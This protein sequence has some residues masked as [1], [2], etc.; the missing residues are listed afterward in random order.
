MRVKKNKK[1]YVSVLATI[2]LIQQIPTYV[3]A[4]SEQKDVSEV[5]HH[6]DTPL[7]DSKEFNSVEIQMEEA[8]ERQDEEESFVRNDFSHVQGIRSAQQVVLIPDV[9]L[10]SEIE[11]ALGVAPGTEI[12]T[13]MMTLLQQIDA[14]NA[15]IRSLEGLQYATRLTTLRV[16]GNHIFDL[17]PLS[18]L[19]NLWNVS[20]QNQVHRDDE[21]LYFFDVPNGQALSVN[22]ANPIRIRF[23][24]H[25]SEGLWLRNSSTPFPLATAENV[26]VSGGIY[27]GLTTLSSSFS[28]ELTTSN[29]TSAFIFSGTIEQPLN[30]G[31]PTIERVGT[32]E[33]SFVYKALGSAFDPMSHVKATMNG[34]DMTRFIR[35]KDNNVD[36]NRAGWYGLN[37]GLTDYLSNNSLQVGL[38]V[39]VPKTPTISFESTTVSLVQGAVFDPFTGVTATAFDSL[40]GV[41]AN[42]GHDITANIEVVDNPVDT[43]I[44]GTYEVTYK[45]VDGTGAV[46]N[47]KR[48]VVVE[49]TVGPVITGVDVTTVELGSVFD[50][51]AGVS[52]QDDVSGDVTA[53]LVV[54]GSVDTSHLGMYTLTYIATDTVGN[55][56]TIE[57]SVNVVDTTAPTITGVNEITVEAGSAFDL[58]A[59]VNVIDNS[60]MDGSILVEGKVDITTIGRYELHYTAED[61][62]GNTTTIIRIVNV[63]D[64]T[65]PIIVGLEDVTI[66]VGSPFDVMKDIRITDNVPRGGELIVDGDINIDQVG[67][68]TVTYTA[69][70]QIG[71]ETTITR[72]VNV[73]A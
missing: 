57:R 4:M 39:L 46:G 54:T 51:L 72:I 44:P 42:I 41:T 7:D 14:P 61:A 69:V 9:H 2:L 21:T 35:I 68:Y 65:A 20:I 59:G 32:R 45:V 28:V 53:S 34:E 12:T 56:T 6:A 1:I 15:G 70:D 66:K 58:M 64:T 18:T 43:T 22:V 16:D 37:Y 55:K 31:T 8:V 38:T 11:K 13:E 3:F 67:T 62:S 40:G 5:T 52:A 33:S 71:N 48:V 17:T 60:T 26:N 73:V 49:D 36:T 25:T 50:S 63:V 10:K 29:F 30:S 24:G 23:G 27:K 47:A 19:K